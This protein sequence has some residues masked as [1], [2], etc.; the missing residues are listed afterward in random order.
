[1][2]CEQHG[3][4]DVKGPSMSILKRGPFRYYYWKID[5]RRKI[6]CDT[7]VCLGH[8]SDRIDIESVWIIP[9]EENIYNRKDIKIWKTSERISK[10]DKFKTDPKPYNDAYHSLMEFLKDKKYFGIE[11]IKKWLEMS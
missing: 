10:Y 9:N 3:N 8:T 4:I 11:D 7:Y 2:Q 6:D 5:T 1:M